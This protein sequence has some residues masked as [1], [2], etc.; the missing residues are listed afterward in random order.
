M[1]EKENHMKATGI[2]TRLVPHG[3]KEAG[4]YLL[5]LNV[6]GWKPV[7]GELAGDAERARIEA[8]ALGIRVSQEIQRLPQFYPQIKI[9][10]KQIMPDHLHVVLQV[11]EPLPVALGLVVRGLKQGCNRAWREVSLAREDGALAASED[12]GKA[13]M[14][15]PS[16]LTAKVDQA[17][18][19]IQSPSALTAKVNQAY[20]AIQS[21][22]ALT[23]KVDQ[24]YAAIQS[25]SALTATTDAGIRSGALFETGYHVRALIDRGQLKK[26]I[27]YVHDNPRRL[28]VRRE[29]AAYFRIH[30]NITAAGRTFDAYGNTELLKGRCLSVVCHGGWTRQEKEAYRQERLSAAREGAALAGAFISKQESDI[31]NEAIAAG[32]SIILLI[33]NGFPERYKPQG[34]WFNLCAEG[35]LLLLAPWAHRKENHTISRDQCL[36]LNRMAEE[37][38]AERAKR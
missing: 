21:P 29:K 15:S 38:E 6:D 33:E 20:A 30:R 31:R 8:S 4:I 10:A 34:R 14:Q 26:M 25:P 5:T 13:A 16:G 36:Q 32:G 7:L 23:A 3:W 35:R 9:L 12:V 2:K 11:T 24:A 1:A 37:I 27:D 18:A 28:A 17:Y 19:A 22:S